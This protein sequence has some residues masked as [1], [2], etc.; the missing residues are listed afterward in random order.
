MKLHYDGSTISERLKGAAMSPNSISEM[1]ESLGMRRGQIQAFFKTINHGSKQILI[2]GTRIFCQSKTDELAEVGYNPAKKFQS[3]INLLYIFDEELRTPLYY[4]MVS[5]SIVDVSNLKLPLTE[6]GLE[7]A[8]IVADKGFYS[9]VNVNHLKSQNLCYIIPLPRNSSLIDYTDK[10]G[11]D[12]YFEFDKRYIW[13]TKTDSSILFLDDTLRLEEQ[14]S[15]VRRIEAEPETFS[16]ADF[17]RL[18]NRF[19][20][21]AVVTNLASLTP[22]EV[23]NRYKAR[24]AI[25]QLFD[26]FKKFL[27]ADRTYM[28]SAN[29]TEGWMFVNFLALSCYYKIYSALD[30]ASLL[31]KFSVQDVIDRSLKINSVLIKNKWFT[32]EVPR[33]SRDLFDSL[34]I[35]IT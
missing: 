4:R 27:L 7:N 16:T 31:S 2:D 3:Q 1:L 20:T 34:G 22:Q 15:Y 14:N 30:N 21:F 32:T 35:H 29:K 24:S 26:S 13:Y 5:G 23:Y 8:V 10:E 11:M 25:E 9:A 33:K 19:G 18:S 28:H 6:S 12:G 17:H